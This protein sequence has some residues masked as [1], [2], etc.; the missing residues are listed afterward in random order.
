[1]RSAS[2]RPRLAG[3]DDLPHPAPPDL[4]KGRPDVAHPLSASLP[5]ELEFVWRLLRRSG[6]SSAD[7]DDAAQQ[8]FL[9]ANA[10]Q[11]RVAPGKLRSFL[12]GTALRV[13]A[14]LRRGVRRRHEVA[15]DAA[16]AAEPGGATPL[17]LLERSR[18][19]ALLDAILAQLPEKLR[20]ALILGDIEQLTLAELAELEAIPL[21]TAASRLRRAREEFKKR[22]A[23][24]PDAAALLREEP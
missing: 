14:N 7:A 19:R 15:D 8:V 6:L 24:H 22:L 16:L 23:A 20:R 10:K 12:Y 9:V 5:D 13:A 17:E 1:M 18:E 3:T 11:E 2:E 21:G 4:E